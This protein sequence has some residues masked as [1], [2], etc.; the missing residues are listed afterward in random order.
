MPNALPPVNLNELRDGILAVEGAVLDDFRFPL[1]GDL[2]DL[3]KAA[4]LVSGTIEDR[5]PDLLNRVRTS[6]WDADAHYLAYEWRKSPIGFPDI[7]LVERA[8]PDNVLFEIEAKSWYVL[9]SDPL[10]ARFLTDPQAITPG[11]LVVIVAWLFD[12]VVSGSPKLLRIHIDDAA[13]LAAVRDA[14]WVA[15]DAQHRVVPASNPPGTPRN[16][17]Q[18][19]ARGEMQRPDGTWREETDNFGK[20]HRLYDKALQQFEEDVLSL[21]AAGK[22]YRDWRRFIRS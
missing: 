7:L 20:L 16:Q 18:T 9:A 10:T 13:H 1:P 15:I 14:A 6:T 22:S 5:I 4:P 3:S 21:R 12:G 2:K 11:T 8:D 19:Q 17:R